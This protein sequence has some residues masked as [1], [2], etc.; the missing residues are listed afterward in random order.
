VYFD[1]KQEE[2]M[3][4]A[5]LVVG[6]LFAVASIIP[7]AARDQAEFIKKPKSTGGAIATVTTFRAPTGGRV[8][9]CSGK[10]FS[11]GVTRHWQCQVQPDE[12]MHCELS[13]NPPRGMCLPE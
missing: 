1:R 4:F 2:D 9:T 10:C 11:D 7:A 13:C 5:G 12:I 3:K 8:M 6:A